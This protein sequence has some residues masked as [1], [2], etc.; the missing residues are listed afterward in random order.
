MATVRTHRYKLAPEVVTDFLQQRAQL[1]AQWRASG[2][3]LKETRLYRLD[4]GT[5]LDVWRW[6]SPEVMAKAF[7]AMRET[8]LVRETLGMTS[9][10][11][12]TDGELVD[13]R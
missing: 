8:P 12:A 3:D 11:S 2:F 10:R 5:Y 1:I 13:E 9:D 7:E 4:D 6:A